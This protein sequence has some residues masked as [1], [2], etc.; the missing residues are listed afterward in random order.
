MSKKYNLEES[1]DF[2]KISYLKS[3]IGKAE[4]VLFI[5]KHDKEM[6]GYIEL[7]RNLLAELKSR[8]F[9]VRFLN[10]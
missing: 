1:D 9:V 3:L 7:L 6:P 4:Y 10:T 2:E 8:R 5:N